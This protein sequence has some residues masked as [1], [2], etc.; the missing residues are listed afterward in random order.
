MQL[1]Q[2]TRLIIFLLFVVFPHTTLNLR[3]AQKKNK[4]YIQSIYSLSL[5]NFFYYSAQSSIYDIGL[6]VAMEELDDLTNQLENLS[7][8]SQDMFLSSSDNLSKFF[9]IYK[10]F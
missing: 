9:K 3:C 10:K 2:N 6:D 5:I 8:H 1:C 7:D 4:N